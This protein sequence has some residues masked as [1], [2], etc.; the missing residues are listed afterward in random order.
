MKWCSSVHHLVRDQ[1]VMLHDRRFRVA[2]STV[3][4]LCLVMLLRV[5]SWRWSPCWA[6]RSDCSTRSSA[7]AISG[8]TGTPAGPPSRFPSSPPPSGTTQ[9]GCRRLDPIDGQQ[10][11]AQYARRTSWLPPSP[12]VPASTRPP[13]W[14]SAWNA[15]GT[16]ARHTSELLRH[17]SSIPRMRIGDHQMHP[18]EAV[19]RTPAPGRHLSASS[20]AIRAEWSWVIAWVLWSSHCER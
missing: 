4:R 19:R 15:P 14:R 5:S 17:S 18:R 2:V 7:N 3:R 13:R 11:P 8:T 6:V 16:A 20:W 9:P 10:L 1:R 12:E